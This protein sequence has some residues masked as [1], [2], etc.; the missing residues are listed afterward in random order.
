MKTVYLVYP[1]KLGE[2]APELYGHFLR[3]VLLDFHAFDA[4]L[5]GFLLVQ[6]VL[7]LNFQ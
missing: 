2:I 7:H 1:E 4:R 5:N 3:K 6:Q